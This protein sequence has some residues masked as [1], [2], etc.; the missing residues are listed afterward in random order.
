MEKAREIITDDQIK[1]VHGNAD[2]G[3]MALRDVVDE[4]VLKMAFNF[5]TGGT[6]F[7]IL[8]EHELISPTGHPTNAKLT[9]KGYS[10][11][12][13]VFAD[14]TFAEILALRTRIDGENP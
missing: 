5:H 10:Y 7:E 13:A 2:F 1:S 8:R 6:Q 12:R 4:G 9:K 11:L 3:G 14:V